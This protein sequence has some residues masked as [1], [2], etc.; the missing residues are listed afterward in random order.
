MAE[1]Y[2]LHGLLCR[3]PSPAISTLGDQA[4]MLSMLGILADEIPNLR[5]RKACCP[6]L[7]MLPSFLIGCRFDLEVVVWTRRACRASATIPFQVG[8]CCF[9][10]AGS[11]GST[12]LNGR[13]GGAALA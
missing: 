11:N 2:V 12:S 8:R 13:T 5:R 3:G 7:V 6:H 4:W 10:G 9:G 1:R